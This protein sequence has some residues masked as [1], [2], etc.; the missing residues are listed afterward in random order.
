MYISVCYLHLSM[1]FS[2]VYWIACGFFQVNL[3]CY[4]ILERVL[5]ISITHPKIDFTT[6]PLYKSPWNYY[7]EAEHKTQN[8]EVKHTFSILSDTSN[9]WLY[10]QNLKGD[11]CGKCTWV[12]HLLL[13][14]SSAFS[15]FPAIACLFLPVLL[16]P[17]SY[18]QS[19]SAV[20]QDH[21]TVKIACSSL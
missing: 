5:I 16:V 17:S 1:L 18:Q 20:K 13:S 12:E 11:P 4:R 21:Q 3:L 10:L 7:L 9:L 14:L 8:V 2:P 15:T 19:G 6:W